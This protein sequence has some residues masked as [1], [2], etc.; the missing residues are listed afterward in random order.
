MRIVLKALRKEPAARYPHGGSAAPRSRRLSGVQAGVGETAAR[1]GI[2]SPHTRGAIRA[3]RRGGHRHL[4]RRSL[5]RRDGHHPADA[6]DGAGTRSRAFSRGAGV[7]DQH[8]LVNELLTGSTPEKRQGRDLTLAD[9][10]GNAAR[11]I[12][13]LPLNQPETEAI[14]RPAR[15]ARYAAIS[16]AAADAQA[17]EMRR[18]AFSPATPTPSGAGGGTGAAAG[19]ASAGAGAGAG[20]PRGA[21]RA[22]VSGVV[23]AIEKEVR[24]RVRNWEQILA[25][26]RVQPGPSH[27]DTLRTQALLARSMTSL[28]A[29]AAA[30]S[31]AARGRG[32]N[33]S[34]SSW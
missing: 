15:R 24:R 21:A 25:R 8:F 17:R 27:P 1:A 4:R 31:A 2:R 23:S 20:S 3:G 29:P 18:C 9:V 14:L 11:G 12:E 34:A 6:R 30:G 26:Q 32:G 7:G 22:I 10:L 5:A 19:V 13:H 28:A 33:R 16:E